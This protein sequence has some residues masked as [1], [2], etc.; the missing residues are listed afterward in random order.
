[1][2]TSE[3]RTR[4][5][6]VAYFHQVHSNEYRNEYHINCKAEEGHEACEP[7][8]VRLLVETNKLDDWDDDGVEN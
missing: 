3:D 2:L 8:L 1:M 5:L 7:L 6:V 4:Y